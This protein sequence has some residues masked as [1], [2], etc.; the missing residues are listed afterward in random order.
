MNET[1]RRIFFIQPNLSPSEWPSVILAED[2]MVRTPV[3]E[4]SVPLQATQLRLLVALVGVAALVLPIS[5]SV[6]TLSL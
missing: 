6:T 4:G 2:G 5:F 3:E 1:K